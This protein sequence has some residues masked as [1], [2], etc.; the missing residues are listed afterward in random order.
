MSDTVGVG[1]DEEAATPVASASFSRRKQSRLNAVAQSLKVA[2]DLGASQIE[3]PFD[4]FAEHPSR[5]D[6]ADDPGDLGPQVP[7]IGSASPQSSHTEGLAGITGSDDMNAVAPRSAIEGS[8]IVPYRRRSQGRVLHPRHES[9]RCMGLP[10]DITHSAVSGFGDVQA[11]VE[12]GIACAE[13][14]AAIFGM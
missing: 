12:P 2:D 13:R 10:L 14:K 5:P 8:Q 7:G 11:K 4:I 1:H 6:L 9:R 3:V